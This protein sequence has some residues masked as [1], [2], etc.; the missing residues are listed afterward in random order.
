MQ[1]ED[2]IMTKKDKGKIKRRVS[3]KKLM[4]GGYSY[5]TTGELPED[6][7]YVQRY[8][9]QIRQLYIENIS[10]T[11][12]NMTAGQI[13]LLNKL[14]TLEGLTRCIEIEAA[15]TGT[16][17]LRHKY[18]TYINHIIKICTHLG[19]ERRKIDEGPDLQTY[20]AEKYPDK[21]GKDK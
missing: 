1:G 13:I 12:D 14:I 15:R 17:N 4:H 10:G 2:K 18:P 11:E 21:K 20:I 5:L 7:L 3:K 19:I 6:K 9:T 16:L 8:L